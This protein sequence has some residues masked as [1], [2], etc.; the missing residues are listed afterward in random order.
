MTRRD[1]PRTYTVLNRSIRDQ[2]GRVVAGSFGGVTRA[3]PP[4]VDEITVSELSKVPPSLWWLPQDLAI[5]GGVVLAALRVAVFCRLLPV[6]ERSAV[7]VTDEVALVTAAEVSVPSYDVDSSERRSALRV[8]RAAVSNLVAKPPSEV[9]V[10]RVAGMIEQLG[11][12]H[13]GDQSRTAS[14]ALLRFPH[15]DGTRDHPALLVGDLGWSRR[16]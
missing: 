7:A 16:D 13:P 6:L 14:L 11:E 10:H 15:L 5:G 3:F 8:L 12:D 9:D 2:D 1:V 4:V